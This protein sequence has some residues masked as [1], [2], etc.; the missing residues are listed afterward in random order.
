MWAASAFADEHL[1]KVTPIG[2][3]VL[4]KSL[5]SPFSANRAC[6]FEVKHLFSHAHSAAASLGEEL[7]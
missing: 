1:F 5:K 3:I 7:V 6:T 2:S 4:P